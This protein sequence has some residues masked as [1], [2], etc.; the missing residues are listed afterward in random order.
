[1]TTT[2]VRDLRRERC[3][4]CRADSEPLLGEELDELLLLVPDWE[5]RT[6]DGVPRLVRAFP[7]PD[8][9]T[10]LD[11]TVRVGEMVEEEGHHPVIRTEWRRVTVSWWTHA[12]RN[13]HRNDILMAAKTDGLAGL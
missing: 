3:V 9:R 13:L 12:I 1:M 4:A 11:F 7:F 10:A 5:L 2:T 8:W 6:V